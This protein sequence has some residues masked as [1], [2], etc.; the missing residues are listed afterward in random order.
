MTSAEFIPGGYRYLPGVFQYS[1]GVAALPGFR[2]ERVVFHEQPPLLDG[3]RRA[4]EIIRTAGRPLTAF[5]ACEL[6]SPVPFSEP[7]FRSFN[8][9]YV[10]LLAQ[11]GLVVD[12]ANPVARSNVCPQLFPPSEPVLH[13][14]CLAARADSAGPTSFVIS[15]SGE[16]PEGK[17]NYR[18]HIVRPG[19]VSPA[20]MRAKVRFVRCEME[21]R[22]TGLGMGWC[23]VTATQLYSVHNFHDCL[24]DELIMP[25]AAR[26]GLTWHF[27]RP[28][29]IGLDFE[30][31]CRGVASE[32]VINSRDS[33]NE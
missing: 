27:C 28:P 3:F 23:N 16:V 11:W 17:A 25:G 12:G 21:R 13:A 10:G 32:R 29:I 4:E 18:D 2:I 8:E 26:H 22:L 5:C 31:D 19:D 33:G 24:G 7:A 9:L 15:G 20:G 14:F 6:R 30:M 1:A